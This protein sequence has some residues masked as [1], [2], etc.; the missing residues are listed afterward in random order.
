MPRLAFG[1]GWTSGVFS[2]KIPAM[3]VFRAAMFVA[4]GALLD[5]CSK[6]GIRSDPPAGSTSIN[7]GSAGDTAPVASGAPTSPEQVTI[8]EAKKLCNQGDCLTAHDRME[9]A[10]PPTAPF[11]QTP[12]FKDIQNRWAKAVIDGAQADSDVTGRRKLLE[13]VISSKVVDASY[14]T[15]AQAVLAKL[16]TQAPSASASAAPADAGAADKSK[17]QGNH[18]HRHGKADK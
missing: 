16:P 15:Q 14:K 13:E 12:E 11:R 18:H 10:L 4:F 9:I 3:L 6:L 17:D 5:P 7:A 1:L 2:T 8:E